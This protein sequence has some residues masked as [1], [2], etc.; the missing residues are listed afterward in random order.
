[1]PPH[2]GLVKNADKAAAAQEIFM[3]KIIAEV[4][5]NHKGEIEIAEEMI[6]VAAKFCGADAVKFQ[7]RSARELLTA[8][9][10]D[11]PHPVPENAYGKTYGEHRERLEFDLDAHRRLQKI[12]ARE[13]VEY[14]CSV[15]D[16]TSAREI[17]SLLPSRIKVPSATNLNF[18]VLEFLRDEFGGEV[19][20]SLGMTTPA[21][22]QKIAAFFAAKDRLREVVFYACTSG[23]PVAFDD[24]CLLEIPALR[25]AFGER[26]KG[27]GFSGHHLG[28]AMDIAAIA[29]GAQWIERH[30][31]LDRTWRGTDHAASLE[32]D[33]LR[34]LCRD[35]RHLDAALKRKPRDIL[36][37]EAGQRKKL[38]REKTL[39]GAP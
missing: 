25:A 27:I 38:K 28:I 32:P 30:F 4:G 21:E 23:Y 26:A 8:E 14:M 5:C 19:H 31:T 35:A 36:E 20:I 15:W 22:A 13:K 3:T 17:A 2:P 39:D 10:Y 6:T 11:A 29:L 34:R 7:K 9:E 1:M 18:P 24:V 16:V 12:C 37:V 33:G